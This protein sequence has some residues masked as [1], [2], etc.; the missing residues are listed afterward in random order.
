MKFLATILLSF[1][2][3]SCSTEKNQLET[4]RELAKKDFIEK[5]DLPKETNIKSEEI[6]IAREGNDLE[7][8]GAVYVVTFTLKSQNSAGDIKIEKHTLKYIKIKEGGLAPQDY[9]LQSFE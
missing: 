5:L 2:A 4:L 8:L 6:E 7:N 9:E 1:I 3:L